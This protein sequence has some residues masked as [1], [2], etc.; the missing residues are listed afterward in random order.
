MQEEIPSPKSKKI[1][2]NSNLSKVYFLE[3]FD[4]FVKCNSDYYNSIVEA[5][6]NKREKIMQNERNKKWDKYL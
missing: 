3:D 5:E 2:I 6:N 4:S 1:P